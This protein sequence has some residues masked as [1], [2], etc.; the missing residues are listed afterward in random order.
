LSVEINTWC[1]L[2]REQCE[3]LRSAATRKQRGDIIAEHQDQIRMKQEQAQRQREDEAHFAKLWFADMDS[4]AKREEAEARRQT[5]ANRQTSAMQQQQIEE[6]EAKKQQEKQLLK[7]QAQI[8][9]CL[10]SNA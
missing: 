2:I 10:P 4:K 1:W 3:E 6:L 8:Q 5:A 9:V 7:E